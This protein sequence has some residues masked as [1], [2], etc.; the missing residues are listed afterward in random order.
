M[1][2]AI[3]RMNQFGVK[4]LIMSATSDARELTTSIS[5]LSSFV[6]I[7]AANDLA[8]S[9][10]NFDHVAGGALATEHLIQLGH[11][12]ILHVGGP[13][14]WNDADRR[15]LGYIQALRAHDLPEWPR[16]E[17]DW[18]APAGYRAIRQALTAGLDFTAVFAGNDPMALG[19]VAAL[20]RRIG[21]GLRR[22][23]RNGLLH[24]WTHLGTAGL[25]TDGTNERRRVASP[26]GYARSQ[27]SA[28]GVSTT[29]H[30][31]GQH[32]TC[33]SL[34]QAGE[35]EPALAAILVSLPNDN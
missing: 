22:Y 34:K 32:L 10:V 30:Q 13:S 7:N 16:L 1:I 19:A 4:G 31:A 35:Q 14:A 20:R 2:A 25:R 27:T 12:H 33:G 26:D 6:M 24:T 17:G 8:C 29:P 3:H 21:R 28:R 23:T 18:S 11:R 5:R 9:T 15:Y